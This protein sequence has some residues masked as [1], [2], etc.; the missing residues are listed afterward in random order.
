MLTTLAH[1]GTR[2]FVLITLGQIVSVIGSGLTTFALGVWVYQQTGSVLRFALISLFAIIPEIVLSPFIGALVDRWDRRRVMIVSD[3]LAG[4][5]TL[6]IALLLLAGQLAIWHI[7]VVAAISAAC[8]AFQWL[9]YIASLPLLVPPEQLGRANGFAQI[10]QAVA[11]L[12]SPALAGLLL[13]AIDLPGVI[14]ID[15]STF[16]VA[17]LAQLPVRIPRPAAAPGDSQGPLLRE[18]LYGWT[19]M[20]V[21]AGLLGLMLLFV[22]T[23]FFISIVSVVITPLVLSFGSAADLGFAL[24]AGGAGMLAGTLLLS[25]WGGPQRRINGMLGF[26]LLSAICLALAGVWPSTPVFAAA[27][28]GFFFGIALSNGCFQ[29]IMQRKVAP[30]VLGRVFAVAGMLANAAIPLAY[31]VAGPLA[32]QVFTPLLIENGPLATSVGR[33]IGVGAGR[34]IGLMFIVAGI[35]NALAIVGAY[36]YRPVRL[37]EDQLPDVAVANE[38]REATLATI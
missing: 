38:P 1:K 11:N 25:A 16:L 27:L 14:L 23:N 17:V 13:I 33:L 8:R 9:A 37:I 21:R 12:L 24:S 26:L 18:A 2:A 31:L 5:G 4:L 34:G 15:F 6:A 10:G 28:C 3:G 20:R 7:Y 22:T 29:V 19:Y 36:L 30:D 35:I 32:D